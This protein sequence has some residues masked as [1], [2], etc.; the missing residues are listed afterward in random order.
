MTGEKKIPGT[1]MF[2]YK[3]K[4]VYD[5]VEKLAKDLEEQIRAKDADIANLR[6]QNKY[7]ISPE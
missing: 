7:L 2:G 1:S 4:D 3:K 5:Y 6:N